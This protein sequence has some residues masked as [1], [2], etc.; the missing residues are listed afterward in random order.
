MSAPEVVAEVLWCD[1]P[2]TLWRWPDTGLSVLLARTK[3]PVTH[4]FFVIATEAHDDDGLPH[5]LEHLIFLGSK[6]YPYKGVLDTAANRLYAR[7]TNAWTA[8][9]HTAYTASHAGADGLLALLPVYA[10]HVLFPTITEAGYTTEVHHVNG[11]G[12]DA[13]VVYCEMQAR[14]N[15]SYSVTSYELHQLCFPDSGYRSETGGRLRELRESCSH[16]KV[17]AYHRQCYRPSGVRLVVV[18]DVPQER[19]LATCEVIQAN[20][21]AQGLDHWPQDAP[22]CWAK[23][24]AALRESVTKRVA[25][26]SDDAETG[27]VRVGWLTFGV[28]E[29]YQRSA[30]EALLTYLTDT[31]VAE[32]QQ[33]F[34]ECQPPLAGAVYASADDYDPQMVRAPRAPC[35]ICRRMLTAPPLQVTLTLD[36]VPTDKLDAICDKLQAVLAAF[37]ASD[38]AALD[39]GRMKSVLHRRRLDILDGAESGPENAVTAA[40]I[41]A[42]LYARYGDDGDAL[43]VALG[44][45]ARVDAME[46]EPPS[47]WTGL[48]RTALASAHRAC[49]IGTPSPQLGKDIAAAEDARVEA[50][51]QALGPDGLLRLHDALEAAKKVNE[52]AAPASMLDAFPVPSVDAISTHAVVTLRSAVTPTAAGEPPLAPPPAELQA[53]ASKVAALA[54]PAQFDD[55]ATDFVDVTLCVRTDGLAPALLGLLPTLC[56][57]QF[58]CPVQR[59]DTLVQHTQVIAELAAATT[60]TGASLGFG[61]GRFSLGAF[62]AGCIVLSARCERS[63]Y[64]ATVALLCDCLLRGQVTADRLRVLVQKALNAVPRTSRDGNACCTALLRDRMCS[65]ASAAHAV[66]FP[67]QQRQLTRLLAR[68]DAQP[69]DVCA[70]FAA[71]RTQLLSHPSRVLVHV[72]AALAQLGDVTGV[73]E[74]HLLPGLA[75]AA[76]SAGGNQVEGRITLSATCLDPDI[77]SGGWARVVANGAVE[78][79]FLCASCEG[80][81]HFEHPDVAPLTV[82]IELLTQLE[83]PFWKELRG[84]GLSYSYSISMSPEEGRLY[85]SL[86]K[87]GHI[88]NATA[89]ATAIVARYA[90]DDGSE[91]LFDARSVETACSSAVF[92]AINRERTPASAARSGLM[93]YLRAVPPA[94]ATRRMLAALRAVTPQSAR[95]ALRTYL[96][97]LFDPSRTVTAA[98]CNPNKVEELLRDAP[99]YRFTAAMSLEEAFP[100]SEGPLCLTATA[101]AG[102]DGAKCECPR[103]VP[104]PGKGPFTLPSSSS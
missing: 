41:P 53:V 31:S 51:K 57:A 38:G 86:F 32:V 7:G 22:R 104:Q 43:R 67:E 5:T 35:D 28:G 1:A 60:Q 34:I 83:G 89:A 90:A 11:D 100:S 18:G 61:G 101:K 93:S 17:A 19:L 81:S 92:A 63:K 95:A 82:A 70:E 9:D 85:F 12:H 102:T 78:S 21:R 56:A 36:S 55:V 88:G 26:P 68:L 45:L 76:S 73:W 13:G 84:L 30:M 50:R 40:A 4:A 3:G 48:C 87:A 37:G 96:T 98:C 49:V 80:P 69:H 46:G 47:F 65:S 79:G 75:D 20:I 77:Q 62:G 72:G 10:D 39:V 54:V 94:G 27:I 71:L 42:F 97:P 58:E 8:V 91:S 44:E 59:G 2:V 16:A 33:A 23:P 52:T 99:H 25:F 6:Q 66:L 15:T 64:G 74:N 14:E 103:C 24:A 29:Q